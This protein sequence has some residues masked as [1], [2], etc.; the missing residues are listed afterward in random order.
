VQLGVQI[1]PLN[2]SFSDKG[3]LVISHVTS[4]EWAETLLEC[5]KKKNH[6]SRLSLT[7]G[8]GGHFCQIR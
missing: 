5:K 4:S 8:I 6:T 1:H 7:M 3:I 2:R